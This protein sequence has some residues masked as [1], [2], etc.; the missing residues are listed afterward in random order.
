MFPLQKFTAN[1]EKWVN[2]L[3]QGAATGPFVF[4]N[5]YNLE[6]IFGTRNNTNTE[7]I[8][9]NKK[10]NILTLS[11]HTAIHVNTFQTK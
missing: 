5:G 11:L 1:N 10:E 6:Y 2:Q 9:G 4:D 8:N 3:K 7:N